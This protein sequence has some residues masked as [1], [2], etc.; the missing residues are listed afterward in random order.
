MAESAAVGQ[1]SNR[2]CVVAARFRLFLLVPQNERFLVH[3]DTTFCCPDDVMRV[4][5]RTLLFGT[6]REATPNLR[7]VLREVLQAVL[8]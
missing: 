2:Y 6:T 8:Q 5:H 1:R 4:G 3:P 7:G